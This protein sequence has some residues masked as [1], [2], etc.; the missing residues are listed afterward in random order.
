[1]DVNYSKLCVTFEINILWYTYRCVVLFPITDKLF[2]YIFSSPLLH[3]VLW[4]VGKMVGQALIVCD[5]M[6]CMYL[7]IREMTISLY[8]FQ[9]GT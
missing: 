1:M 2:M 7:T 3:K 9:K 8:Q 5:I 4:F 6:D